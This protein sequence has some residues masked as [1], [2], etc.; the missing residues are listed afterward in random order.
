MR[1]NK[2][3]TDAYKMYRSLDDMNTIVFD[4]YHDMMQELYHFVGQNLDDGYQ[5]EAKRCFDK[6]QLLS[7]SASLFNESLKIK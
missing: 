2:M 1:Q 5:A 6:L 7:M 4:I 3:R